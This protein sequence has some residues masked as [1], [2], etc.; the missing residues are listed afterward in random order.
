MA[1][2][3]TDQPLDPQNVLKQLGMGD[4][5]GSLV[6]HC[7]VVKRDIDEGK[8]TGISFTPI[9]DVEKELQSLE[10]ALREEWNIT[11]LVLARRTGNLR[12]GDTISVVAA[13]ASGHEQAFGVCRQAIK[14][15]KSMKSLAK[16][17]LLE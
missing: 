13:T 4:G 10:T 12:V 15:F 2:I 17:E 1:T 16:E 11:N 14:G 6:V 7:A 9:D 5:T 8:S 3:L